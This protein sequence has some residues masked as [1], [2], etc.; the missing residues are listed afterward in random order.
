MYIDLKIVELEGK[1]S[2]LSSLN[3]NMEKMN[4]HQARMD[5]E[6][7]QMTDELDLA[8]DTSRRLSQVMTH[9]KLFFITVR[10]C[11]TN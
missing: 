6:M 11:A 2:E 10:T 3:K 4:A 5:M 7:Q 9:V 1:D 8:R